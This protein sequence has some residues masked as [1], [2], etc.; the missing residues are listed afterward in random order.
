[1][2]IK[3][4]HSLLIAVLIVS[5]GY[6]A[7]AQTGPTATPPDDNRPNAKFNSVE[8]PNTE[9]GIGFNESPD[10]SD[11]TG[12]GAQVY[13]YSSPNSSTANKFNSAVDDS[14]AWYLDFLVFEKTDANG[15]DPDGGF[16]FVN[17]GIDNIAQIALRIF[18][19]G[20]VRFYNTDGEPSVTV[21]NN[22]EFRVHNADTI[23]AKATHF[24]YQGSS[25][26]GNYLRGNTYLADDG[27][28]VGIGTNEP[29]AKLH[30]SGG[31]KS[32][33]SIALNPTDFG[34]PSDETL[35]LDGNLSFDIN[36]GL[37]SDSYMSLNGSKF[38]E[39]PFMLSSSVGMFI[40]NADTSFVEMFKN[41]FNFDDQA[42]IYMSHDS[43]E[44]EIGGYTSITTVNKSS[45]LD[46]VML[47]GDDSFTEPQALTINK[48]TKEGSKSYARTFSVSENGNIQGGSFHGDTDERGQPAIKIVGISNEDS[49]SAGKTNSFEERR[50]LLQ[51]G[52][53][54]QDHLILDNN[55]IQARRAD[56]G[57]AAHLYL[58]Y[59][60]GDVTIGSYTS[61]INIKG[62]Q[63]TPSDSSLKHNLASI[64]P[65]LK[66]LAK[67]RPIT[68][69]W[70][71]DQ[72]EK[73]HYGLIAQEVETVLPE[74]VDTDSS[75]L[76]SVNYQEMI[77]ILLQAINELNQQNLEL[78]GKVEKLEIRI[79]KLEQ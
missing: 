46:I 50:G 41:D 12:E 23:S 25:P 70:I 62:T 18:G 30:V 61:Q 10:G 55:E 74:L 73:L 22:G 36:N 19:S 2:K 4:L 1:M 77:P 79:S 44:V 13:L 67:L 60:G 78:Q 35:S 48:N 31:I 32:E 33:D 53:L 69:N 9:F 6:S 64:E 51:I 56:T 7:L 28:K 34:L 16:L 54:Y 38:L 20:S 59:D 26:H 37:T 5:I 3:L 40:T 24:N 15:N 58:N 8:L 68:F 75:G 57:N 11:R 72:S 52:A 47:D 43:S 63:Y 66:L 49:A 29:E 17:K 39:L 45:G 21:Y 71:E 65:V 27:S 14:I 42:Y 76:K